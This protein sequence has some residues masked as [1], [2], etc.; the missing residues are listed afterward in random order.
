MT[1]AENVDKDDDVHF[2]ELR[3]CLTFLGRGDIGFSRK[4]PKSLSNA[5]T[6][7]LSRRLNPGSITGD[8]RPREK[9][10]IRHIC[11]PLTSLS[12]QNSTP[13]SQAAALTWLLKS[14]AGS[15]RCFQKYFKNIFPKWYERCERCIPAHW[16]YFEGGRI[17]M[18]TNKLI[19]EETELVSKLFNTT[20]YDNL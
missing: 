16:D 13:S 8:D 14:S 7:A 3:T 12:S 11:F 5:K 15:R 20:T 10:V 4:K 1:N 2:V 9:R 6:V 19:L 17:W 18:H